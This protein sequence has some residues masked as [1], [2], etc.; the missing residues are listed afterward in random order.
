MSFHELSY[1]RARCDHYA[2]RSLALVAIPTL[3]IK[4]LLFAGKEGCSRLPLCSVQRKCTEAHQVQ[5]IANRI[6]DNSNK[7]EPIAPDRQ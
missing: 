4:V 3:H 6:I 7:K 2:G 1:L 5:V